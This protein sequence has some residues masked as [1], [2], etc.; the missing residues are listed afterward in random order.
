[1]PIEHTL[2]GLLHISISRVQYHNASFSHIHSRVKGE[3]GIPSVRHCAP[4]TKN[5]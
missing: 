1:M 4:L 2:T 3:K 5:S